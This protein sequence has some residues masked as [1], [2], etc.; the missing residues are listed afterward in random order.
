M[1]QRSAPPELD[2]FPLVD[3]HGSLVERHGRYR[4]GWQCG[5]AD[6]HVEWSAYLADP[7]GG[8]YAPDVRWQLLDPANGATV[9][10]H[11]RPESLTAAAAR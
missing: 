7:A 1:T 6:C 10:D 2:C 11:V 8:D 5:C 9:L 3:Y 4:R